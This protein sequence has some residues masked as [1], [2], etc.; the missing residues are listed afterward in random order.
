MHKRV[1]KV[2]G[3]LA[4]LALVFVIGAAAGGGIVF[5][6]TQALSPVVEQV[7]AAEQDN[8]EAGMV[9]AWV[10]PDGSAA[11]AGVKRG[12][13]L[14]K[15][16]EQVIN[17]PQDM[18]GYLPSLEPGDQVEL[19][20]LHG[21][22]QRSLTADLGDGEAGPYLGLTPCLG[23]PMERAMI[24]V[25]MA[26]P[27]VWVIQ[28]VS[29]SPAD[30]AG[31]QVGDLITSVDGQTLDGETSL[32]GLIAEYAPGDS[33]A[34]EVRSPGQEPRQASVELG[35]HP[36]ETGK[37]FLG[38]RYV[39]APDTYHFED[40]RLPFGGP[41][42][43]EMHPFTDDFPFALPGDHFEGGAVVGRVAD[44]SPAVS[45]GLKRG[46]V[47]TR[48]DSQPIDSPETLANAVADRQPGD[49]LELT[50]FRPRENESTDMEVTLAE[51]P[52]ETG[53]AYL[54]VSVG[55]VFIMRRFEGDYGPGHLLPG[56]PGRRFRL[57]LGPD[58]R[59]FHF[60]LEVEPDW[61]HFE[62]LPGD[63]CGNDIFD[64]V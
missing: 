49:V 46:D 1:W 48:V 28:V 17:H 21:D 23:L 35:E 42:L 9:I 5:A 41:H 50:V 24:S 36:E 58:K 45:A 51:H 22:E 31:L 16:D 62:T 44:D 53:K 11:K 61:F 64:E 15:I 20:V 47:I 34:L 6:T 7:L 12:D 4:V 63:C 32:A 43:H 38:V 30:E 26:G 56:R 10:D 29:G 60:D 52:E 18:I 3:L 14:L 54:G 33:V 37:A 40:R 39:P 19:T 25:R 2:I 59:P 8:V 55:G 57:P 27:G 13:I